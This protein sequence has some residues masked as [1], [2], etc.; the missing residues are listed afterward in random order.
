MIGT[1]QLPGSFHVCANVKL[2]PNV[3]EESSHMATKPNRNHKAIG[4]TLC[5]MF[6]QSSSHGEFPLRHSYRRLR[7]PQA[8]AP[9]ATAIPHG[10]PSA[11]V[12][13]GPRARAIVEVARPQFHAA[14]AVFTAAH[15]SYSST[16]TPRRAPPH[17]RPSV[18]ATAAAGPSATF[19][20]ERQRSCTDIQ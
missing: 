18:S 6:C 16:T 11:L 17:P 13:A 3:T 8:P 1:T 2:C 4:T 5:F 14:I 12:T 20:H 9:S 19:P 15:W 10:P 7:Q